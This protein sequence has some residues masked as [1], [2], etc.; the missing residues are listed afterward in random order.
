MRPSIT[1]LSIYLRKYIATNTIKIIALA[2]LGN[3]IVNA[4]T[5]TNVIL[6]Y[7]VIIRK[8][9]GDLIFQLLFSIS[10]LYITDR[11]K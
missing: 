3:N 1:Y 9:S 11:M 5:F 10:S 6:V 7:F 8:V 2:V 4:F